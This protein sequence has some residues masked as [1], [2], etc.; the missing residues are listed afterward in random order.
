MG[1]EPE[2]LDAGEI[3]AILMPALVRQGPH[4]YG[5]MTY[6]P[7]GYSDVAGAPE[8]RYEKHVGR[9]DTEE[10]W[11]RFLYDVDG[12]AKWFVGHTR[13]ATVG[14][15]KNLLNDHPIPHGNIVGVHNGTLTNHK[16]IL[17][18][19]GR[20][21]SE[22]VVDSE[23]VFAAVNKWGPTK[24][25]RKIRGTMVSVFADRR[26]P[27]LLKIARTSGRQLTIGFTTKG[28]MIFASDES[29][30]RLLTPD[31]KFD[32]FTTISENRLLVVRDGKI[33]Q[34]YTF[35][36]P[37]KRE[38]VRYTPPPRRIVLPAG[39]TVPPAVRYERVR[40]QAR[41]AMSE[42]RT[43]GEF[44]ALARQNILEENR[45]KRRGEILFPR[46]EDVAKPKSKK[47]KGKAGKSK[48]IVSKRKRQ[49]NQ[50]QKLHY[51]DGQLLTKSEYDE[52]IESESL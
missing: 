13:F 45:A 22:T 14:D 8:I 33:I 27:Y 37:E 35:R 44:L 18:L 41:E 2:K 19:T 46:R 52:V 42:R 17:A 48:G 21:D 36:K 12:K 32:H 9:S 38:P 28:N 49:P 5:W 4:A 30:L 29:A 7:D 26:K 24:G 16:D 23:A 20:E 31:I 25:L 40:T 1:G 50:N 47:P 43:A 34:R 3:A 51:Y 11:K 6:N 39:V 10:A 15:P